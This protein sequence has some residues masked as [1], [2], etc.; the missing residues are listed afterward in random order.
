MNT[1]ISTRKLIRD[2]LGYCNES[3][4]SFQLKMGLCEQCRPKSSFTT[5]LQKALHKDFSQSTIAMPY[6]NRIQP[7]LDKIIVN[8][9]IKIEWHSIQKEGKTGGDLGLVFGQPVFRFEENVL[10]I[11]N[12]SNRRGVLVQAKTKRYKSKWGEFTPNQDKHIRSRK[13]YFYVLLYEYMNNE[14]TDLDK[15]LWA[16]CH[17]LKF[18][19]MPNITVESILK[20]RP[21]LIRT[22]K[23]IHQLCTGQIGTKNDKYIDK[24][25]HKMSTQYLELKLTWKDP[26]EANRCLREFK[27]IG[28][29]QIK[30]KEQVQVRQHWD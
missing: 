12:K 16:S 25:I 8:M 11:E 27:A 6:L 3:E 13:V 10:V 5:S 29:K 7:L 1:E 20:Q 18:S 23:I 9:I 4:I 21:T 26:G 28:N 15:F 22:N 17:N 2:T 14:N 19:D 24:Y 30:D